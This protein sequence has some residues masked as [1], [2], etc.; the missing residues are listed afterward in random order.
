MIERH[1]HL[2]LIEH[3]GEISSDGHILGLW[4]CDCGAHVKRQMSRVRNGYSKS[5]GCLREET[6]RSVGRRHGM[7]GTPTYSSWGA[8][9]TRCRNSNAKDFKRYGAVGIGVCQE[10]ADSFEAFF[11]HMGPR[12]KGTTLD[13]IDN[14]KGY[15]PGNCRW[16]TLKQQARNRSST[17]IW[18]VKGAAFETHTEAAEYFGVSEHTV[19][20]WVNGEYDARRQSFTTPRRDCHVTA[21][22]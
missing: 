3:L 5:C 6:S 2:S 12:P 21:R 9:I 7:K 17:Y 15:E 18:H 8:M 22:Y 4:L 11:N 16:G 1:N 20:R 10:W 19:W 14:S 13:R